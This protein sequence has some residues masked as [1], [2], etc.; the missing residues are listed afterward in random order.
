LGAAMT[1]VAVGTVVLRHRAARVRLHREL[2]AERVRN[3]NAG[4]PLAAAATSDRESADFQRQRIATVSALLSQEALARLRDEALA[5][6][7]HI[8]RSHI[9]LHKQG[10]T[11]AYEALHRHAP[12]CLALYHSAALRRWL[13]ERIGVEVWPTALHDQSS[14]SL[15]YYTEAGDHINWHYDHNFY[16]GRHFTVLI[17]LAACRAYSS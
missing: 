10:G 11:V 1:A 9:P 8:E 14:C 3:G 17:C 15:L 13:S 4:P 12:N 7:D 16:R 2:A 6:R 5:N